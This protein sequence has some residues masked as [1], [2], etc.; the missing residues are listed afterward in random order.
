MAN[1]SEL[2]R[3]ARWFQE[4]LNEDRRCRV[5]KAGEDIETLVEA[6]QTREAWI[7]IHRWYQ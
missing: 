5:R 1:Q 6:D 4:A 2:R 7:K 3:A